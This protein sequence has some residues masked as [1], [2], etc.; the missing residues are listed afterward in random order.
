MFDGCFVFGRQNKG[1][2][3]RHTRQ[4]CTLPG[5]ASRQHHAASCAPWLRR[6]FRGPCRIR[7]RQL[8]SSHPQ[9][10]A[11]LQLSWDSPCADMGGD[12]NRPM[13]L[14]I[15]HHIADGRG[16]DLFAEITGQGCASRPDHR[17]ARYPS[18]TRR[19]TSRERSFISSNIWGVRDMGGLSQITHTKGPAQT[20]VNQG[21]I[22]GASGGICT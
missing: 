6:S 19:K 16:T 15:L 1:G 17:F 21:C 10:S 12:P 18:T 11:D 3:L 20:K 14:Q 5:P 4:G 8:R 7:H 13:I 9:T 2:T 22:I